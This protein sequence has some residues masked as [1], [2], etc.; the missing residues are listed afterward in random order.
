M[1]NKTKPQIRHNVQDMIR[2]RMAKNAKIKEKK[3]E[4]LNP[5]LLIYSFLTD[6]NKKLHKA[7]ND[8][9]RYWIVED[10]PIQLQKN[11][12]LIDPYVINIDIHF[13]GEN[14]ANIAVDKVSIYW[15]QDYVE[16]NQVESE[17]HLDVMSAFMEELGF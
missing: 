16:K 5:K 6:I 13:V 4:N 3:A 14:T 9:E 10:L 7:S 17:L 12:S 8:V 11:V 2:R 15:S 1:N